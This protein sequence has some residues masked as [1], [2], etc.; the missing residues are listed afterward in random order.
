MRV[1]YKIKKLDSVIYDMD[2]LK[3]N[4]FETLR[5]HHTISLK[6]SQLTKFH[7]KYFK[8]I[9]SSTVWQDRPLLKIPIINIDKMIVMKCKNNL[10]K[11]LMNN[12]INILIQI[13]IKFDQSKF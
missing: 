13:Y 3:L 6:Y 8:S 5:K 1:K 10:P 2:I 4:N 11:V 9:Y 7:F 12:N